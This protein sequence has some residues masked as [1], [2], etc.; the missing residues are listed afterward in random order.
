MANARFT[1]KQEIFLEQHPEI[2]VESCNL[3]A[4]KS[5]FPA[6]LASAKD[7]I[8]GMASIQGRKKCITRFVLA[9][10]TRVL[11]I[12]Q[13]STQKN[14]D[15]LRKF[16]LDATIIKSAFKM[17]KL[18]AALHLD[19]LLHV[20]NAKDLL[21]VAKSGRH[22]LEAFMAALGGEATLSKRAVANIVQHEERAT[23]EPKAAALQA[24][25]ACRACTIPFVACRLAAVV[26][27]STASIDPR[28]GYS[29]ASHSRF[30]GLKYY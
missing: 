13:F 27:I 1:I 7:N 25:A 6:F 28:V 11:I 5:I 19:L 20:N 2:L 8:V 12:D 18:A 22:S 14:K 10:T 24:W 30:G 17:D 9:T 15:L 16:L 21:S 26:P 4:I 29:L 23:I 3:G